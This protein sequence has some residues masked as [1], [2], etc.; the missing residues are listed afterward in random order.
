MQTNSALGNRETKTHTPSFAIARVVDAVKRSKDF[1]QRILR[2]TR[3]V[4]AY[5]NH[6][7]ALIRI[8]L[9]A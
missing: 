9:E 5:G 8:W 2:H 7:Q 1:S 3:A 4:V 6:G